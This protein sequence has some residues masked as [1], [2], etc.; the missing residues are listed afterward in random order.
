M[1]RHAHHPEL[2]EGGGLRGIL[3]TDNVASALIAD[4]V[5]LIEY[6]N[7]DGCIQ[8]IGS[9]QRLFSKRRVFSQVA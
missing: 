5:F 7:L 9:D 4:E 8:M 2:V 3:I 6:G 1:V